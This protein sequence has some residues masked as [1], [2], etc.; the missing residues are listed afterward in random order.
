MEFVA[1]RVL[2][3]QSLPGMT[4]AER[5]AIYDEMNR[6]IAALHSVDYQAIGLGD[7]GKPGNYFSRQIEGWTKQYKL[8]ETESIPAMDSLMA[9]L[10]EHRPQQRADPTAIGHR[11]YRLHDL[12]LDRTA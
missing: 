2:W 5:S 11:R 8:S 12:L 9:W 10:P 4:P 6:V 7:Y 3:D 1:G